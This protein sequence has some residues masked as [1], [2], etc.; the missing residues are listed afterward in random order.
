[1][2]SDLYVFDNS[3][4]SNAFSPFL[5]SASS[6]N[7]HELA[8]ALLSPNAELQNLALKAEE[9]SSHE[10]ALKL[11]QRSYS[12][13]SRDFFSFQPQF[14]SVLEPSQFLYSPEAAFRSGH[15]RRVCSTGD[16]Q[17]MESNMQARSMLSSRP[18]AAVEESD[19]KV[20][21]G[22]YSAEERKDRI[23]RYRAKRTQ[24]NFTKTIKVNGFS[25]QDSNNL[26]CGN[27]EKLSH[28]N[29]PSCDQNKYACRKTLADTRPRVRGR[30]ARNDEAGEIPKA[31]M[32]QRYE[33]DDYLWTNLQMEGLHQE[34]KAK[35]DFFSMSDCSQ[36][37]SYTF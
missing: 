13:N 2:S 12:S 9:S 11:M 17:K 24:R 36:Y 26:V 5:D 34:D 27:R 16:L 33:D 23:D 10:T 8:S 29:L 28:L 3:Y 20:G 1:M 19:F 14:E 6:A 30:F 31:S 22:R 7:L 25:F 4:Y 35:R 18:L 32:Y 21:L 37:H 15:M